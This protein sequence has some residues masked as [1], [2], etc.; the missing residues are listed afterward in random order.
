MCYTGEV[1]N[2]LYGTLGKHCKSGLAHRH[3]VLMVAE[4]AECVRSQCTSRNMEYAGEQFTRDLVHVGNHKKK[5]LRCRV[6][7]GKSTGLK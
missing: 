6:S 7:C 3:Y 4:D 2:F 1:H 5:T